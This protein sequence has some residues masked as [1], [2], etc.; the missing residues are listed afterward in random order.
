MS[1]KCR[2]V[3]IFQAAWNR[4]IKA[5]GKHGA[6]LAT[7]GACQDPHCMPG[8]AAERADAPLGRHLGPD[9]RAVGLWISSCPFT[10]LCNHL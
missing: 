3:G 1:A 6:S 9:T 7:V 10:S 4:H 2:L 5:S 8:P